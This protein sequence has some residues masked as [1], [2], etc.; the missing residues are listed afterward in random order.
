MVII[1]RLIDRSGRHR[2][3]RVA[4][5]Q[6]P[7]DSGMLGCQGNGGHVVAQS[8]LQLDNPLALA[9][10]LAGRRPHRTAR[11]VNQQRTQ[12]H[13]TALGNAAQPAL[14]T[15]GM[16]SW[17]QSQ[18]SGKLSSITKQRRVPDTG[19]NRGCRNRTDAFN[20]HQPFGRLAL[21]G[22][23]ADLALVLQCLAVELEHALV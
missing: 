11:A 10:C 23:A 4:S 14:A 6:S 8:F 15:A 13:V 7:H 9:V 2:V 16:L 17:R 19:H 22:Q 12:S 21:P 18:S 1:W 20:F 5:Q 3:L